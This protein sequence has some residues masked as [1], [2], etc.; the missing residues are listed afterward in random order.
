MWYIMIK[1]LENTQDNVY[2]WNGEDEVP[3]NVINVVV[4]YVV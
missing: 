4:E 2:Y 1:I 3:E